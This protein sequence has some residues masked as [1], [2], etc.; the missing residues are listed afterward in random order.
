M[1]APS[2]AIRI[3]QVAIIAAVM[4]AAIQ[5][6]IYLGVEEKSWLQLYWDIIAGGSIGVT[7]GAVFF[8]LF[9]AIGWV[10]GLAYGAIGLIGMATGGALGGLGLGALVNV[11]R[12]PE[13]Y[14]INY[15]TVFGVLAIGALVA[16]WLVRAVGRKLQS[17]TQ[18]KV[19]SN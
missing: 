15:V 19:S 12:H 13:R 2:P 10:S 4:Y 7:A 8:V 6:A 16:R 14:D 1:P 5:L 18:P 11:I 9:G 3:I 17:K